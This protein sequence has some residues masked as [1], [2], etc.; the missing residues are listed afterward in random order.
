MKCN[1]A[2]NGPEVYLETEMYV[3]SKSSKEK[4]NKIK[5]ENIYSICIY[6]RRKIVTFE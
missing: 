5:I 6:K 1:K 2:R 4:L 3:V